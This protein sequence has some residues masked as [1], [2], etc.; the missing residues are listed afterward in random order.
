VTLETRSKTYPFRSRV[1]PYRRVL[2]R[3][4][5]DREPRDDSGGTGQEIVREVLVCAACA[6]QRSD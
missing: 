4:T 2:P 1:N 3:G 5:I 6:Q